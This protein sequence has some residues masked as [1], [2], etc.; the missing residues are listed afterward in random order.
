MDLVRPKGGAPGSVPG[1]P[2]GPGNVNAFAYPSQLD[3]SFGS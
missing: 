3:L 2:G 1:A